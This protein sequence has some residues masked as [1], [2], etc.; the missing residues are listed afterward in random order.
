MR[1]ITVGNVNDAWPRALELLYDGGEIEQ[2]RA[3]DVLVFPEPVTTEYHRPDQRVLFCPVRRA[4]PFF[5]LFEAMWMLS[6]TSY[7]RWLDTYVHDFSS[8]FAEPS[9]FMHGAYGHRWRHNFTVRYPDGAQTHDQLSAIAAL[10]RTDPTTRQAVLSMWSPE[11]DLCL[12]HVRDRPCN[13]HAYFR[14]RDGRL[15]M[16]VLCRSNDIVWGAYGA[17]YVHMSVMQEYVAVR[18]GLRVG[19]YYQ[20]SN[21][22]HGYVDELKKYDLWR[23]SAERQDPYADGT[24]VASPLFLPDHA[25]GI[26]EEIITWMTRPRDYRSASNSNLFDCLL[27]PMALAHWHQSNGRWDEAMSVLDGVSHRDWGM[28]ARQWIHRRRGMKTEQIVQEAAE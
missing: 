25:D 5:H 8:R 14:V 27:T 28:A 18:A 20:V 9:G 23:V 21:N 4:N 12:S 10:L 3:G 13:T 22:W 24:A 2:S 15:D 7:A 19:V 1:V 16:T 17:N 26:Q 11:R 6:G